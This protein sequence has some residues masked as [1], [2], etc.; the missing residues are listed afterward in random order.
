MNFLIVLKIL[1][2]KIIFTVLFAIIC[3]SSF[4]QVDLIQSY[5][6][7]DSL[8]NIIAHETV[9]GTDVDSV[10]FLSETMTW[11]I[12]LKN[13]INYEYVFRQKK[14]L[15]LPKGRT[16]N[17]NIRTEGFYDKENNRYVK[18]VFKSFVG[19]KSIIKIT[20]PDDQY[21]EGIIERTF[22]YH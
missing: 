4:G 14:T 2:M 15:N 3:L 7:I 8:G 5:T 19:N 6:S 1:I 9:G 16:T 22:Q 21:H 18:I 12:Y 17:K 10:I 11:K 13:G 20:Y